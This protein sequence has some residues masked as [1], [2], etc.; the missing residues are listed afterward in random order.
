MDRDTMLRKKSR[1]TSSPDRSGWVSIY[2][3]T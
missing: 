3:G 2:T 1:D